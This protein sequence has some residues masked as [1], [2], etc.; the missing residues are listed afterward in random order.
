LKENYHTVPLLLGLSL[1]V[2][3][4]IHL[5]PGDPTL[6]YLP[7][8]M[9]SG[10]D[11]AIWLKVMTRLGLDQPLHV[12]Y[13][14]WLNSAA[15]GDFGFAYGYG[16]PVLSLIGSHVSTTVQLQSGALL[17]ALIVTIPIGI[18]SATRQ[19]SLL[20][21]TVTVAEN[22][23]GT[24]QWGRDILSRIIVGS[25]M[26]LSVGVVSVVILTTI[27]VA[28]GTVAGYKR[29]FD[30]PLMR[31]VDIM[32]SIAVVKDCEKAQDVVRL[33][34]GPSWPVSREENNEGIAD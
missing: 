25:R 31:F 18:I 9:S 1:F 19:Y 3:L 12:Q 34:Y 22:W 15:R 17:L 5:A 28:I 16:E 20:D 14:R 26:S 30:G 27:G 13:T 6:F 32:M 24:D 4:L 8:E 7:P 33:W 2:F 21:N 29:Q 10:V 11:P 23:L